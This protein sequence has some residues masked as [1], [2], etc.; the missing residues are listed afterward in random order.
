MNRARHFL[1]LLACCIGT[2]AALVVAPIAAADP[3]GG[4]GANNPLLPSCEAEGGNIV[5]GGATDCAEAG[6][7][8]ITAS[9][10]ILGAGGMGY[11]G[12]GMGWGY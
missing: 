5:S 8:Q 3:D 7:S 10:G 9:P 1:A 12:F 11:G 2:A 6:N 4:G